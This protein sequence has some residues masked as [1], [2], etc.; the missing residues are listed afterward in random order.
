MVGISTLSSCAAPPP[1]LP[2]SA[3]TYLRMASFT[4]G[5]AYIK[6]ELLAARRLLADH[7][8]NQARP[9]LDQFNQG[10]FVLTPSLKNMLQ[11]L[12]AQYLYLTYRPHT[13]LIALSSISQATDDQHIRSL[14]LQAKI[15]TALNKPLLGLQ[16]ENT[17]LPLLSQSDKTIRVHTIWYHL[18]RLPPKRL[19]YLIRI[20]K[21]PNNLAWLTLAQWANQ[22]TL[23]LTAL[24]AWQQAY[25]KHPANALLSQQPATA[26]SK[27]TDIAVLLPTSG[28]LSAIGHAIDNGIMTAYFASPQKPNIHL[29]NTAQQNIVALYNKAVSDGANYIIGPLSKPHIHT[30]LAS[31]TPSVPTIILN[32]VKNS[33]PHVVQFGLSP[34]H[35]ARYLTHLASRSA[36]NQA[37]VIYPN[38]TWGKPIAATLINTWQ[39]LGH[40]VT[41]RAPFTTLSSLNTVIQHA[42][43]INL[44]HT[45]INRLTWLINQPIRSIIRRRKDI[46]VIFLIATP[47]Q[48]RQIVPLLKFY[49]V[50]NLPI[51]A[52]S[53]VYALNISSEKARTLNGVIFP[54]MPFEI[55]PKKTLSPTLFALW[56]QAQ[57]TWPIGMKVFPEL[58]ALGIDSYRLAFHLNELNTF[59]HLG[60]L[61]ATGL[62]YLSKNQIVRQLLLA[63]IRY[64]KAHLIG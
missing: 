20:A 13:A 15:Y 29:Y 47:A 39:A 11:L 7:K 40:E 56:K 28:P 6:D 17:L 19:S 27:P 62:L 46:D 61:G 36:H 43:E 1:I 60:M 53:S 48:A 10:D 12:R 44:S 3:N 25:P 4:Q 37:L 22:P 49:Y 23:S 45:R 63:Q 52:I 8:I 54:S 5:S 58:Y 30:L 34:R 35:E 64:G 57:H 24:Q 42:L 16:A 55:A 18:R 33:D 41:A 32:H 2:N 14:K 38:S 9:V 31:I 59:P 50:G 51:Y 21:N 26:L